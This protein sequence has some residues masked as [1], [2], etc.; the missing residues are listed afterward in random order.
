M[1][2]TI[3]GAKGF[4]GSHLVDK[5]KKMDVEYFTPNR[6]DNSIFK[7]DL[8]HVIYCAGVTSDYRNRPFDTVNAHVSFLA[9]ILRKTCFKSF[10]Y[11]SSTRVYYN[12]LYGNEESEIYVNPNRTDDI[13]NISKLMGESLCI[14]LNDPRIKIA[15]LSNVC[16]NDFSSNNFIYSII[17]DAILKKE[18]VLKTTFDSEKDYIHI[19][20]VV[21]L[22]IKISHSGKSKLYNVAS[23]KNLSNK[24]ITD[25]IQKLT[26]C[27]VN[28]SKDAKQI[29]FPQ[30]HIQKI[31]D[32]FNYIPRDVKYLIENLIIDYEKLKGGNGNDSIFNSY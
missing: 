8:G 23:G 1:K 14:S 2:T 26:S 21:E 6:D 11:L 17:E 30:I 22:L 27:K 5:L 12:N 16:G 3:I 25:L 13:F 19:D 31:T 29:K 4:I 32:E 24:E 20:D 28:M 18:I 9:E 15:R 10:L 7:S